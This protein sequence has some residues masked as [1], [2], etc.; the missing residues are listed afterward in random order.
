MSQRPSEEHDERGS[1]I[2]TPST[3]TNEHDEVPTVNAIT[4]DQLHALVRQVAKAS[5]RA[6]RY[7][8]QMR[9]EALEPIQAKSVERKADEWLDQHKGEYC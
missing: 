2:S 9:A 6:A 3:T 8:G 1:S 5:Y 7:R 4:D